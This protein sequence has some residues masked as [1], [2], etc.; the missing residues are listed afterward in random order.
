MARVVFY[1]VTDNDRQHLEQ[2][3]TDSGHEVITVTDKLTVDNVDTIAEVISVFVSSEFSRDI[4]EKAAGLRHI[5]CRSTGYDHVDMQAAQERGISISNVPTYGSNTVAEYTFALLL[6]LTRKIQKATESAKNGVTPRLELQGFDL[7]GKTFGIIGAGK[8]GICSATIA[9]GFGMRILAY[10]VYQNT[11]AAS[12]IGFEY[13]SMEQLLA[14]SDIV[15]LH[16][17]YTK[18]NHHLINHD[19]L[20]QMKHGAILINTARGELVNNRALIEA[21]E[22]GQIGGAAMD[23]LEGEQLINTTEE[24]LLVRSENA[25][26]ESLRQSLEVTVLQKMPNVIVTNHN[27]FNTKEAIARINQTSIDNIKQFLTGEARNIVS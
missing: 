9:K 19:R 16:T 22:S 13:V 20:N 23:V 24:L 18:D 12:E 10:D 7:H 17:P 21:L 6:N 15:S 14:E 1:D 2:A 8:I 11:E 3:F 26:H 27:A 5:A 4:I 25:S